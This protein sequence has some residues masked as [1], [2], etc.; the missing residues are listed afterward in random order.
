MP[1]YLLVNNRF[2][3]IILAN[4]MLQPLGTKALQLPL[5]LGPG[6]S[7]LSSFAS[8]IFLLIDHLQMALVA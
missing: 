4:E 3:I 1:R 5:K 7:L 6:L 8:S 2:D